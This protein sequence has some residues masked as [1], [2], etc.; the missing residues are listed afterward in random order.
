ML[1][2]GELNY[3]SEYV[4]QRGQKLRCQWHGFIIGSS[5]RPRSRSESWIVFSRHNCQNMQ[6][7]DW[8]IDVCFSYM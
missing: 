6:S 5:Q 2:F 1:T 8:I 7:F 3:K 4:W